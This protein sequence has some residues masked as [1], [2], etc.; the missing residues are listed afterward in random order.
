ML[1]R[2]YCAIWQGDR[3][4]LL[5]L[6]AQSLLVSLLLGT[7]FG[8]LKHQAPSPPDAQPARSSVHMKVN[9]LNLMVVSCF[10]FGCNTAAK[11]LV[12]ERAIFQRERDY[13][14]RI[15]S[16]F[17]SKLLVLTL[18]GLLQASLLFGIVRWWCHPPGQASL[19][20]LTLARS[21]RPGQPS[22]S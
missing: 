11:E 17:L 13:N 5:A 9:L 12:K 4:A 19:Q 14:L 15:T 3:Q 7:L 2:R 18:I 21:P 8:D 10:W 6:F 20:W 22:A 16:Y 1:I